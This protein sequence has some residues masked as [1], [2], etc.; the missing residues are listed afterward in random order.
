MNDIF[1]TV[2]EA[3]KIDVGRSIVR[4]NSSIMRKFGIEAGDAVEIKGER[5]AVALV[6][7]AKFEDEGL[8]VVRMDAVLRRNAGVAL[9]DKV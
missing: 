3:E 6:W 4:L 7:R 5:S 9:G 2:A 1:L 8:D